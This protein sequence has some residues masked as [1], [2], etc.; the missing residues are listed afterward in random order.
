MKHTKLINSLSC[1][2]RWSEE[3]ETLGEPLVSAAAALCCPTGKAAVVLKCERERARGGG[4][5]T[6]SDDLHLM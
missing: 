6:H 2:S 1:R 3:E 4:G 5:D